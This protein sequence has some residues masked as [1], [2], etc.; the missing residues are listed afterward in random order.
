MNRYTEYKDSGIEWIGEIPEHWR[1]C[2]IKFVSEFQLSSVDRHIIDE[3]IPVSICH[4]PNVYYNEKIFEQ[5][6]LPPGT[7]SEKE[8]EQYLVKGGDIL[9]TK[10]SESPDDIGV[11]CLVAE[12]LENTVCGYHLGRYRFMCEVEPGFGLRYLQSEYAR[13]Y[14]NTESNGITRY[15]LG[16]DTLENVAI[17]LPSREEQKKIFQYLDKKISQIDSLIEKLERKIELLREYRTSLISLCV[18]KGLKPNVQMK[19]SGIEWIGVIPIHWEVGKLKWQISENGGGIWGE[20]IRDGHQGTIVIRSTEITINGVWDMSN[21]MLRLIPP[22]EFQKYSL[23]EGDIVITKSS[24]S[25]KHIGKSAVVND[26]IAN[27]FCCY[28]NFVQ[29]IRLKD[30]LPRLYHY[31]LNSYIVREQYRYLTQSTTGLGNLNTKSINDIL[32][33]YIPL[34]TQH[35]ILDYLDER[36]TQIDSLIEKLDRKII[37]H[38]EYRQSLISNVVTGKVRVVEQK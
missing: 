24:G 3:E 11:P 13:A 8:R 29:R 5:T 4:Y 20:D 14:F 10:D 12:D 19:D 1:W 31:L 30:F 6:V 38:K 9:V 25:E 33:P 34:D 32:L 2:R 37:L 27:L 15:A 7:C 28:S 16:K 18:T 36:T 26:E 22:N 17:L 35:D 21:P 23:I